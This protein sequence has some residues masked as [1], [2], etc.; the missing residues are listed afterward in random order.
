[1]G[2][3][4]RPR[5]RRGVVITLALIASVVTAVGLAWQ[6]VGRRST[7]PG[8]AINTPPVIMTSWRAIGQDVE[9]WSGVGLGEEVRRALSARGIVVTDGGDLR[10]RR[11]DDVGALAALGRELDATYVLGGTVGRKGERSEIGMQLV[12]VRDGAP[13][14]ASTFWRDP[15]D[16]MSLAADLALAVSQALESE[17]S[18]R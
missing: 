14:W 13:V 15:S 5:G 8:I 1:M 18:R 12:R 4:S 6:R 11:T 7:P 17:E 2:A 10:V 9:P 3:W 16:L